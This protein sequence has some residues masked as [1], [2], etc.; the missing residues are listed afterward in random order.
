MP[1]P[2]QRVLGDDAV[3]LHPR[4][5]AYVDRLGRAGAWRTA[6][7]ASIENGALCLRTGRTSWRRVSLPFAPRVSPLERWDDA[8]GRQHVALTLDAPLMG[9]VYE[10]SGHFDDPVED[11]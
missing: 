6:L 9:R 11:A 8:A 3:A 10:Y 2:W 5:R 4:L 1:S 7:D